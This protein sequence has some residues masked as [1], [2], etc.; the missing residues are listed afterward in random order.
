MF[1]QSSESD[2]SSQL[3]MKPMIDGENLI[4]LDTVELTNENYYDKPPPAVLVKRNIT[5]ESELRKYARFVSS[6]ADFLLFRIDNK[7]TA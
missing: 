2:K 7:L 3:R 6:G 1:V 5:K 4:G